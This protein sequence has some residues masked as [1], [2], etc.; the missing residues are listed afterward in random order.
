MK[1]NVRRLFNLIRHYHRKEAA[2]YGL[3]DDQRMMELID[4]DVDDMNFI[5]ILLHMG[6]TEKAEEKMWH[7][8]TFPRD[9]MIDMMHESSRG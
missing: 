1:S 9:I 6:E 4:G 8:D 5:A 3:H 7:M 2:F